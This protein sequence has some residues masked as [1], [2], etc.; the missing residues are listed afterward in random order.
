L[1]NL[2]LEAT[3]LPQSISLYKLKFHI[4]KIT[5]SILTGL[6]LS[7]VMA[8]CGEAE[9]TSEDP[10]KGNEST[11]PGKLAAQEETTFSLLP[12][13]AEV[14]WIGFKL[15]EKVGVN[16][17]FTDFS[18][19]GYNNEAA[20][21]SELMVGTEI[22]VKVAS[23]K[24]GDEVRDGKLVSSFFGTMQDS[25]FIVATLK[26]LTGETEGKATVAIKMNG[27]EI[28]KELDWSYTKDNF[29]FLI[30]GNINVPDWNAQPALDALNVVCEEKHKGEG[31]VSVTWPDVDV[32]AFVLIDEKVKAVL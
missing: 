6:T 16:G 12:E 4:M 32:S 19:T 3:I 24:T 9:T 2:K 5:K 22:S 7:L 11:E 25:E 1:I 30:H 23:T 26:G 14:K 18:L 29:T 21:I 20:S 8:S 10:K 31:D 17:A 15:A 13:T 27:Q 28:E